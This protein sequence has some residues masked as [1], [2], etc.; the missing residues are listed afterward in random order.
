MLFF[1][2]FRVMNSGYKSPRSTRSRIAE[3]DHM[4]DKTSTARRQAHIEQARREG[5][6]VRKPKPGNQYFGTGVSDRRYQELLRAK[7]GRFVLPDLVTM[8]QALQS[9]RSHQDGYLT[10]DQ[11]K[12]A[13]ELLVM[14]EGKSK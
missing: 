11:E 13:E 9:L 8:Q 5:W 3:G 7:T 6:D 10:F 2:M 12:L 14:I 1:D 4:S